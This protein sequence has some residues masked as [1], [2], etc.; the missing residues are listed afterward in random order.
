MIKNIDID[1]N[2]Y[3]VVETIVSFAKKNNMDV[4]AEFVSSKEIQQKVL[5]LEIDFSQG[6]Y[7]DKPK[8]FNEIEE[9]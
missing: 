2:S 5:E 4:I 7:I 1:A 6:Y 3:S 9:L 8:F